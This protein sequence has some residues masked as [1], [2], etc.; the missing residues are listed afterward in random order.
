M[1]EQDLFHALDLAGTFAFAVSGAVAA[2]RAGLDLFGILALAF[3]TACGGGIARDLLIGALPPASLANPTVLG[4]SLL[5]GL[6]SVI[7]YRWVERL[8]TPVRLF[9]AIGLGIFAVYGAHKALLYGHNAQV[10]ILVGTLTAVGG[11]MARDMLLARVSIVLEKELY[12]TLA[13]GAAALAVLSDRLGWGPLIGTWLPVLA[14]IVLRYLSLRH[15]WHLP[16][17]GRKDDDNR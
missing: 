8:D 16:R 9:D 3:I 13:M 17:F 12:A 7:A 5:G 15:H 10:A 4:V 11:G 6:A 2:R 1:S 14:C